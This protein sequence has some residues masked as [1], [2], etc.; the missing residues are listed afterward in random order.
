MKPICRLLIAAAL[1]T[2]AALPHAQAADEVFSFTYQSPLN[3]VVIRGELMGSLQGDGNTVIVSQIL[4]IPSVNGVPA[5]AL[6]FVD[7]IID[8]VGDTSF[9]L[10]RVSLDGTVMDFAACTSSSCDDGFG[11]ESSG[12]F[13]QPVAALLTSF[14]NLDIIG[15]SPSDWTM[16]AVP[17]VDSFTLLALGL[18]GLQ[19]YRRIRARSASAL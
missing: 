6:P 3:E 15:Y 11:F 19:G 2:A 5:V 16:Q 13:G 17:E 14:G 8:V 1:T 18:I 10:P 9:L 7:S 4:G 12:L